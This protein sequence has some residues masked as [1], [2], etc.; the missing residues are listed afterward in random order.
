MTEMDKNNEKNVNN[1]V[2]NTLHQDAGA[3]INN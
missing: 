2:G 1:E 3:N